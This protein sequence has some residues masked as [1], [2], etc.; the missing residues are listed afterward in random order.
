MDFFSNSEGW[1]NETPVR[2]L[3][4]TVVPNTKMP[5]ARHTADALKAVCSETSVGELKGGRQICAP[6]FHETG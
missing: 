6:A 3:P 2:R 1:R 5:I 4:I